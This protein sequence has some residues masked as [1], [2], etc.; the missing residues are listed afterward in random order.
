M[1][2]YPEKVLIVLSWNL[3]K[4][5]NSLQEHFCMLTYIFYNNIS[6]LRIFIPFTPL[7]TYLIDFPMPNAS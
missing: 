2:L 7:T 5:F 3:D 6:V 1:H 4:I